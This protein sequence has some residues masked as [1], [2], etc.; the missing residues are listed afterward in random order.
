M[1]KPCLVHLENKINK[2]KKKIARIEETQ[3]APT[4]SIPLPLH[5]YGRVRE[6]TLTRGKKTSII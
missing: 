2:V 5:A 6:A 3:R 4:H 1:F